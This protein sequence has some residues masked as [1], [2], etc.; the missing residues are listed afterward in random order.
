[1]VY[2]AVAKRGVR[3]KPQARVVAPDGR[4]AF[5]D[6]GIEELKYGVEI[7]GFLNHMAR[8]A[9]DRRRARMLATECEWTIAPYAVEEAAK[10]LDGVA[11]DIVATVRRLQRRRAA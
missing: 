7:D 8:F 11:D 9:R 3:L 5:I 4:E 2:R 6:L 1:M 10:D